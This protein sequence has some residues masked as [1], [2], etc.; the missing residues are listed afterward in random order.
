MSNAIKKEKHNYIAELLKNNKLNENINLLYYFNMMCPSWDDDTYFSLAKSINGKMCR[1][2]MNRSELVHLSIANEDDFFCSVNTFYAQ[3]KHKGTYAKHLNALIVDLD[4]YNIP[5]LKGLEP[6]QIIGL[7]KQDLDYPEPSF[8]TSSGRGLC[9]V[10][11]LEKT[12]ATKKSKNFY[13]L[14]AETMFSV[15][16]SFGAD[17]KVKDVARVIRPDG[18]K[19]SKSG[20]LVKIITPNNQE[21]EDYS[22]NP[23]R[24]ELND[25]AE[26]FWGIREVKIDKPKKPKK[27]TKRVCKVTKL[28]NIYSLYCARVKDLETLVGL[29]KDKPME[30]CREQ[31]LFLYRLQLLF[32]GTEPEIALKMTL[33]LNN[34]LYDPLD[35]KEVINA[36][37]NAVGNAEVYHRLKDKY[38]DEVNCSLNEYLGRAGV[39]IY[40]NS[41][42]IKELEITEFE[43]EHMDTLINKEIKLKNKRAKNQE[44]YKSNQE[45][46]INRKKEYYQGKL[47][48]EGKMSRAE[49][50][51][52]IRAKIKS[53][54]VEGFTQKEISIQLKL[55]IAT[56]KRHTKY[57]KENEF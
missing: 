6:W 18:T 24:Y 23:I 15:F 49:Q 44:Y 27:A 37:E 5:H 45:K 26:Y 35:Q 52:L 47:K 11:L 51:N 10:W 25:L 29:R 16:E 31:L 22:Q 8:Y 9:I 53:L 50:N 57:I 33:N 20:K 12:Y 46:E 28:R 7:M 13:K 48:I 4:Y 32:S 39:Y 42:I 21:L 43:M 14:I 38:S 56:V 55:G 17:K 36:T 3:G 40:K 41:T 34:R 30:G 1:W 54:M 19:N 2:S